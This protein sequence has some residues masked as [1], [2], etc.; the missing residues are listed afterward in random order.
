MNIDSN[1][2]LKAQIE[3]VRKLMQ[4]AIDGKQRDLLGNLLANMGGGQVQAEPS[5]LGEQL[6]EQAVGFESKH[7]KLARA[8]REVM[9]TLNKMGV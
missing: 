1:E 4:T 5:H 7:P 9:D 3:E 8:L 6:E 2:E